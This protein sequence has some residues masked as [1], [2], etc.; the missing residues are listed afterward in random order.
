MKLDLLIKNGRVIDPAAGIDERRNI[1]IKNG[2]FVDLSQWEEMPEAVRTLEAES[3]VV[4]PGLID[5]H[6]HVFDKGCDLGIP[7]DLVM[8]PYGVTAVGEGGSCGVSN[9]RS[10]ISMMAD[11][12]LHY[13]MLVNV[14]PSGLSTF[15]YP[16]TIL[17]E[18]WDL[19]QLHRAFD[20]DREKLMGLKLRISDE[21]VGEQGNYILE[22]SLKL[23]KALH[24]RLVVHVTATS[25]DQATLVKQL[26]KDDIYCHVYQGMGETILDTD[27]SVKQAFFEAQSRGVILDAASGKNNFCFKVA[28]RALAEG[29]LP[30][31]ICS[32]VSSMNYLA[33]YIE[34]GLPYI[35]SKFLA[36]GMALPQ[37]VKRVTENPAKLMGFS[38]ELG[39]MQ[40]GYLADA[41][42]FK[43]KEG[44]FTFIDADSQKLMGKQ[45]LIPMATVKSGRLIYKNME[46]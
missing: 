7:A 1:G 21:V 43:V 13:K 24:T 11:S 45:M 46:F 42:V 15:Q 34:I 27:G 32:D 26:R 12:Q 28:K 31:V 25:L 29:L 18:R 14:S 6:V 41:A 5:S 35:M 9:Y 40:P 38:G 8:L 10:F 22:Q 2:R 37:I 20:L 23:A 16:E 44:D 4:T 36:L 30:D 19:D 17:P 3:Y 33:E 39:S